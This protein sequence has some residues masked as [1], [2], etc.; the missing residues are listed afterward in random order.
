MCPKNYPPIPCLRDDSLLLSTPETT[1]GA[2]DPVLSSPLF[3]FSILHSLFPSVLMIRP[4]EE[5][6]WGESCDCI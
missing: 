1:S 6:A 3:S 5:K 4:Q 2:L